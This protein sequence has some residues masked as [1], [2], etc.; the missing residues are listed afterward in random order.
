MSLDPRFKLSLIDDEIKKLDI[1]QVLIKK[2]QE[3][4]ISNYEDLVSENQKS[5]SSSTNGI[6]WFLRL[7]YNLQSIIHFLLYIIFK[8]RI[9]QCDF[10]IIEI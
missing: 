3:N 6:F 5:A 10:G 4:A 9:Q 2:C 8:L 7:S 1:Q